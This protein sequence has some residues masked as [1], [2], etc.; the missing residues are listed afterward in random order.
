MSTVCEAYCNQNGYYVPTTYCNF[1]TS[2]TVM[3]CCGTQYS[4]YCCSNPSLAV[5]YNAVASC[6]SDIYWIWPYPVVIFA[7]LVVV[8]CLPS[9]IKHLCCADY[10]SEKCRGSHQSSVQPQRATSDHSRDTEAT[11]VEVDEIS[12]QQSTVFNPRSPNA[13]IPPAYTAPSVEPPKY[14]EIEMC[15]VNTGFIEDE[16]PPS[17]TGQPG[18]P[19]RVREGF[20]DPPDVTEVPP[21]YTEIDLGE[22]DEQR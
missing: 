12:L 15:N 13:F 18:Q 2:S 10:C 1:S 9:L 14:E 3:Y 20:V 7:I 22:A 16:S 17:Y 19:G 11:T 21:G 5:Y 8:I 6:P 4:R